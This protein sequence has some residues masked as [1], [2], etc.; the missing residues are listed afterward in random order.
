[1]LHNQTISKLNQMRL[2]GMSNAYE[3]LSASRQSTAMTNDELIAHLVESE[4]DERQNRKLQRLLKNA[5]FRYNSAVEDIKFTN[6]RNLDKSMFLRLAG[7]DFIKRNENIIITG[8]TGVGKSHLASALGNQ[9]CIQGYKTMYFNTGKLLSTLKMKRADGTYIK[10]IEKI[11]RHELIILDDF[12]LVQLD[13]H[14]RLD[15]LEIIEDRHTK[16]STIITS[17]LP[18]NKWHDIIGDSTIADAILDRIIHN[19]YKIDLKG[20]SLRIKN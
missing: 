8:A 12:G 17:Q 16:S 15:L 14:S 2:T 18:V 19:A 3:L 1:M 20:G 5:R 13:T 7:C 6:E 4:W 10:E 11:E 9:A